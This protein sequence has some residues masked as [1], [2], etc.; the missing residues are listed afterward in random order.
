MPGIDLTHRKLLEEY[1]KLP[2]PSNEGLKTLFAGVDSVIIKDGGVYNGKAMSDKILLTIT[3][4]DNIQMLHQL[5]EID[6]NN[7]MGS[8][9]CLGTY[10]IE[11]HSNNQLLSTIGFHHE[12]SIRYENWKGDAGLARIDELLHFLADLGF[13][14][15]LA[16]RIQQKRNMEKDR[17]AERKW[18]EVAPKCFSKYWTQIKGVDNSYYTSLINYL[19]VEIPD[20]RKQIIALLQ[21]F[22]KTDNFWTG[23]P[24]Y[25]EL[26]N[27][28]LK[29]FE[30]KDI[31]E[32]YTQSDRN[33]K[34]RMGLGR[35]LCSYEL[36]KSRQDHIKDITQEVIGDLE[37]CFDWLGEKRGINEIFSLKNAKNKAGQ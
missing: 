33:Y 30:I 21:T 37:K 34:T 28:I 14:A 32:A 35:F 5:M 24:S 7:R 23:Y 25:E 11:L 3:A 12:V 16:E 26:P 27:D 19:N 1:A 18:L 22:G 4:A 31:I 8:C 29:T 17:V 13:T 36:K 15:P 20:K 6:E 2:R 10:A 9:L